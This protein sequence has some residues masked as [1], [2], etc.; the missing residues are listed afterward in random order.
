[1]AVKDANSRILKYIKKLDPEIIKLRFSAQ[2]EAMITKI[3]NIYA[4]LAALD[5]KIKEILDAHPETIPTQYFYY[6][7][8]GRELWRLKN[9]YGGLVLFKEINALELKWE[10]RGLN[11]RIMEKMRVDIFGITL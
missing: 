8:Y 1:M 10:A 11:K 9:K 6:F 4:E 3:V 2:K 5:Q 7:S